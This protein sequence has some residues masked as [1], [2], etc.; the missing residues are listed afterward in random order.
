M[1]K[2]YYDVKV[3]ISVSCEF[4][5]ILNTQRYPDVS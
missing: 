3:K 4:L 5:V 1:R 2:I